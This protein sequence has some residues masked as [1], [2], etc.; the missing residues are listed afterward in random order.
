MNDNAL[1]GVIATQL[2]AASASAGW[3]YA[4]VQKDQPTQEGIPT[5][6]TIFFEKLFDVEY[7]FPMVSYPTYNQASNTFTQQE[8]QWTETHFQVSALVIQDV[9]NLSLP[10]A[11]DVVNYMKQYI[12]S[13]ACLAQL[14]A[15]G[16][17][18]LRIT[19]IRN[20][21]FKDDR[22][23]YEANPNFDV[24][25]QHKRTITASVGASNKVVGATVTGIQGQ[26]VFPV[27][28]NPGETAG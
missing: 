13:R 11:S 16:V 8:D 12:N 22:E 14:K 23:V 24:I 7:G 20:P 5:A 4:V 19:D 27:I 1:I 26:G 10:T 28:D 3:N 15:A 6:P 21:Y 9:T 17:G 18:I 25:L 2:E